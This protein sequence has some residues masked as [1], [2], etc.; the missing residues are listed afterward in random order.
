MKTLIVED[1]P[2]IAELVRQVVESISDAEVVVASSLAPA[3]N[4]LRGAAPLLVISD[5]HLPDGSGLD[6]IRAAAR[7][8]PASHRIL[9]TASIDRNT[10]MEARRAG[11]TG[12]IAKPF[13]IETLMERLS[14]LLTDGTRADVHPPAAQAGVEA[15]L[16]QRLTQSLS[17]PWTNQANRNLA[18]AIESAGA[19]R[20]IIQLASQEP[21]LTAALL[22]AA[23][24]Q[25]DSRGFDSATLEEA[26]ERLGSARALAVTQRQAKTGQALAD[27]QLRQLAEGLSAQQTALL[28][29]LSR[30]AAQHDL[31]IQPLRVA[32]TLSRVGELAVLGALQNFLDYGQSLGD[33][34]PAELAQRY[35]ADFGNRIKAHL[36]LPFVL[37]DLTGALFRLPQGSM[38]KDQV[39][40]RIAA[41]ETGLADDPDQLLHLRNWIGVRG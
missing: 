3:L 37:R 40:M 25:E 2:F 5:L 17:L 12:F 24:Q 19:D 23:N 21:V 9:I 14:G 33:Y 26:V 4:Y 1:D 8:M 29:T 7:T 10:V 28:R 34:S 31:P 36:Q 13:T 35:A 15:F 16:E 11:I 32:A 27:V 20:R 30:L 39:L 6:I 41:L 38:R 22:G 18:L